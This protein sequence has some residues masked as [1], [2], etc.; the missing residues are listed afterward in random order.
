MKTYAHRYSDTPHGESH[1]PISISVLLTFLFVG[2]H[3]VVFTSQAITTTAGEPS[4]YQGVNAFTVG[5][6]VV[7]VLL[8]AFLAID[9]R[10]NRIEAHGG[11]SIA[12]PI[13]FGVAG[14]LL[15]LF[16][17]FMIRVMQY[18]GPPA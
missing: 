1:A 8:L 15:A 14:V 13:V 12:Q 3:F 10:R 6:V 2:A 7:A 9:L 4:L 11:S 5:S 16:M 18:G 17:I